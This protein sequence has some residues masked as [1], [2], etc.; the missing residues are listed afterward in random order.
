VCGCATQYSWVD[1]FWTIGSW[2][3]E[4]RR[5]VA[6]EATQ[7]IRQLIHF[8]SSVV[9][10]VNTSPCEKGIRFVENDD[11]WRLLCNLLLQ[12]LQRET[13]RKLGALRHNTGHQI[14]RVRFILPLCVLLLSEPILLFIYSPSE[15]KK[16]GGIL[17]EPWAKLATKAQ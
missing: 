15:I 5:S 16:G 3:N 14:G 8:R 2:Q 6:A 13:A 17:S 12:D 11:A 10:L 1:V 4:R 9:R 7:S